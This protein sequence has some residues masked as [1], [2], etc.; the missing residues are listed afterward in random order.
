MDEKVSSLEKSIADLNASIKLGV[1]EEK[2]NLNEAKK[3]M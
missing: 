1:D 3:A 2:S